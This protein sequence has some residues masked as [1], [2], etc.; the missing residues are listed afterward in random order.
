[1]TENYDEPQSPYPNT[2][3][4]EFRVEQKGPELRKTIKSPT[5]GTES[6]L[7]LAG[8]FGDKE[9]IEVFSKTPDD[10]LQK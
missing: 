5:K 4:D 9:Y 10:S 1:M 3:K 8:L 2:L 7:V 6:D